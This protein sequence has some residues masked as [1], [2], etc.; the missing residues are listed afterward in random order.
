MVAARRT[1]LGAGHFDPISQAIITT[2]R[3][4]L[5]P[6][7]PAT[8]CAVDVGAGTGHHLAALLGGLP[9]HWGL[10]LDASRPALRSAVRAHPRIAAVAC[11]VW[12]PLPLRSGVID[13]VL[14]VFAPRNPPEIARVLSPHGVLVV[15]TPD[16]NHLRELEE[17]M[18]MLKVEPDKAVR[19]HGELAPY[20]DLVARDQ[21]ESQMSLRQDDV[22]AL[23]EMGP[24]VH[25]I[26]TADLT[27][28]LARQPET[29]SVTLSTRVE[30][31]RPTVRIG[32]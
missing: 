26:T 17:P 11:D 31:F 2:A 8:G 3:E 30:A 25:H 14:N 24:S 16:A 29:V 12:Q 4:L 28:R 23:V 27:R 5:S 6:D 10:A 21:I 22:K 19:L 7:S 1:F 20:F 32:A 18:A 13:L 9:G 15:V